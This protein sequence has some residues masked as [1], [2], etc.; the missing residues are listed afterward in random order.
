MVGD[1]NEERAERVHSV[2]WEGSFF[3]AIDAADGAVVMGGLRGRMFR[4]EDEGLTW[5]VVEKPPTSAVVALS[6]MDDGTLVGGGIAGEILVSKDDGR[7]FSMSPASFTAG[8]I[9]DLTQG[10]G[11]TLLIA[12]PKGIKSATLSQ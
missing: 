7:S 1:I 9:F 2:P 11:N 4:T 5:T 3:T 10:A 6:R 8:P 12:G